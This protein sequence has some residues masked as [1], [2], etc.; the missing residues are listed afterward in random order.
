MNNI[1]KYEPGKYINKRL[2]IDLVLA[3]ARAQ[4]NLCHENFLRSLGITCRR[5]LEA[6]G[7]LTD[8]SSIAYQYYCNDPDDITVVIC[9]NCKRDIME[10]YDEAWQDIEE[11][12]CPICDCEEREDDGNGC[13]SFCLEC[14][15]RTCERYR[16]H[17]KQIEYDNHVDAEIKNMKEKIA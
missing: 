1:P 6:I 11:G 17:L 10:W 4:D 8:K 14:A 3:E 2:A 15:D 5:L 9:P 12:R 16:A 7:G 13:S